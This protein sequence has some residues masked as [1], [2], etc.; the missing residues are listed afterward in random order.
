VDAAQPLTLDSLV[1][2]SQLIVVGTVSEVLL[3]VANPEHPASIQTQS[4]I[5]VDQLLF[6]SLPPNAKAIGLIQLGGK[7]PPFQSSV[8]GD[9][10]V[11]KG[12]RYVL[13]LMR[14]DRIVPPNKTG[15]ARFTSV[16]V[17]TGMVKIVDGKV[18]FSC[19]ANLQLRKYDDT[20]LSAFINTLQKMITLRK[21]NR[22]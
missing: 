13:F 1:R 15:V 11:Q 12:E 10:V 22:L 3:A 7:V 18:Q 4:L 17:G 8:A 6:G 5:S 14:D 2:A 19:A 20:E 21:Q 9:P 16:G